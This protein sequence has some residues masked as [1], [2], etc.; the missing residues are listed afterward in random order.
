MASRPA[1]ARSHY[2]YDVPSYGIGRG[3]VSPDV[4]PM[5]QLV[6]EGAPR[7]APDGATAPCTCALLNGGS[8]ADASCESCFVVCSSAACAARLGHDKPHFHIFTF[9]RDEPVP[10]NMQ[11]CTARRHACKAP[12][13]APNALPSS[14][15]WI[16]ARQ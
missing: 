3:K 7:C 10:A 8:G 9:V 5:R 14:F 2:L 6:L 11:V 4:E 13:T 16:M 12:L 15:C 1:S